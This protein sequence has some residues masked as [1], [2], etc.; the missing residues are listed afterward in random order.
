MKKTSRRTFINTSAKATIGAGILSAGALTATDSSASLRTKIEK[1]MF[2]HHVYFWLKNKD[3]KE[4]RAALIKGL[5]ALSK[6]D[7][8]KLHHIGQPADTN[9]EVI[10]TSYSVSWLLFFTN[11]EEEE[12]YQKDP[13]HQKFVEDCKHLWTKVVV[14]DSVDVV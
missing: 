6:I 12:R 3:S 1:N 8:I 14:Y 7:Y 10:D 2:I 9:R 4:D 11:K 5:Q 13:V